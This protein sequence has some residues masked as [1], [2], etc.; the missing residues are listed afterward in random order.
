MDVFEFG[1]TM[2]TN[3]LIK[4][5]KE[6]DPEGQQDVMVWVPWFDTN[7]RARIWDNDQERSIGLVVEKVDIS[8]T[9]RIFLKLEKP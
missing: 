9:K 5:L 2:T 4:A 7:E 6:A 1:K 3:E 8:F